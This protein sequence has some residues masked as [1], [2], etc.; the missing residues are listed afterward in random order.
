MRYVIDE[1][2][3]QH[4]VENATAEQLVAWQLYLRPTMHQDELQI[5]KAIDRRYNA[6]AGSVREAMQRKLRREHG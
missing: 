1:M 4:Q 3:T 2:P 5:V 6:L